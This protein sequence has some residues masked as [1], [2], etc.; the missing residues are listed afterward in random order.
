MKKLFEYG[1]ID[2]NTDE[3]RYYEP[4]K[5]EYQDTLMEEIKQPFQGF[6][7]LLNDYDW[8]WLRDE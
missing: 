4:T 8:S 7:D 5:N 3:W 6:E 1:Y 2:L